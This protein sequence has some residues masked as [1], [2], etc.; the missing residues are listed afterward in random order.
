M[1]ATGEIRW[2][3]VG[4]TRWPLTGIARLERRLQR[5]MALP[6]RNVPLRFIAGELTES[7]AA[8]SWR[9]AY[10]AYAAGRSVWL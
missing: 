7:R 4:R 10:V 2:P 9:S 6:V 5:A 3:P 8:A 1:A